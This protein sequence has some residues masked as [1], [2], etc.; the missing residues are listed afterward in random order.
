MKDH[1]GYRPQTRCPGET[2]EAEC[3]R[4]AHLW[5]DSCLHAL[6]RHNRINF[7]ARRNMRLRVEGMVVGPLYAIN[8]RS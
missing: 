1:S 2:P 7:F 5:G 4:R 8:I 3:S 6:S